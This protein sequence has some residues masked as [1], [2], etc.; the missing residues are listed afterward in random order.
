MW[1]NKKLKEVKLKFSELETLL[2]ILDEA[3]HT[4]RVKFEV[5]K[6]EALKKAVTFVDFV[7][8]CEDNINE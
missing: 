7:K 4:D 3:S 5:A 8:E 6:E 2:S 1:T